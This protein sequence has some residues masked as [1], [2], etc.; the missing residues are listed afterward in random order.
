MIFPQTTTWIELSEEHVHHNAKLIHTISKKNIAA[1]LKSNAYGHGLL[2]FASIASRCE[3]ITHFCVFSIA[4][5]LTIK[6]ELSCSQTI[7]VLGAADDEYLEESLK[8][9]ICISIN[10]IHGL[11][12]II[13][14]AKKNNLNARITIKIDAGIGRLGLREQ[15]LEIALTLLQENPH[16]NLYSVMTHLSHLPEEDCEISNKQL[17]CFDNLYN[18]IHT[19][20]TKN[21][22]SK[23]LSHVYASS[24]LMYAS[25]RNDDL[26]RVGSL[27]YGF[28]KSP[29]QKTIIQRMS[30]DSVKPVLSLKTRIM[31]IKHLP[32]CCPISYGAQEYT[33]RESAI[34][35]L[36]CG[37][38]EGYPQ[39][40]GTS[41]MTVLINGMQAPLIGCI[42][43]NVINVDVTAIPGVQI[44]DEV[45]LFGSDPAPNCA[46]IAALVNKKPIEITTSLCA[47]LPRIRAK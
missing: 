14:L 9:S 46:T 17:A 39:P 27:L 3:Y 35:Y 32:S 31:S 12:K 18:K 22:Q 28:Y 24:G 2:E 30:N 15:D 4:E 11:K 29:H 19:W 21:N 5:A 13:A 43:M 40:L 8:H 26:I 42:S 47:G 45:T 16:I 38:M 6:T 33:M 41:K 36:P 20:C 1:V 10:D 23:P 25:K 34:A 37:Y 44:G 7:I